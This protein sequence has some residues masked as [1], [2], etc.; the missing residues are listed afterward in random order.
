MQVTKAGDRKLQDETKKKFT[1][2]EPTLWLRFAIIDTGI[3]IEPGDREKIFKP[4]VQAESRPVKSGGTGLGLS[5]SSNFVRLMGSTLEVSSEKGV[6][7]TFWF[8]L[9][10]TVIHEVDTRENKTLEY[11]FG[12]MAEQHDNKIL[13]VEDQRES[14]LM[15]AKFLRSLGFTVQEAANGKEAVTVN[16]S[17]HPDLVLMDINMPV[18]DG[19][20]ATKEIK[21]AAGEAS[22]PV[23]ALTAHAFAE[24][25][26]EMK[27]AGC[28][29]F[30]AKPFEETVLL[31]A[32]KRHLGVQF[33]YETKRISEEELTSTML[34]DLPESQIRELQ[35]A[36]AE[37]NQQRTL[38]CIQQIR[39]INHNVANLLK[40]MVDHYRFD[41]I[42]VAIEKL[43][44]AT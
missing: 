25:R 30:I 44:Q 39:K 3:G 37:L 13:V 7:S 18:M 32:L 33:S 26:Q 28:D 27:A 19:L 2:A 42:R 12:L 41:D 35:A 34:T 5:I 4:F 29:D 17:F 40:V 20:T 1:T 22:P 6:G 23:I 36:T 14:R 31:E 8:D 9:P 10:V 43:Y 38:E 16:A 21:A 11:A 24:E 15:L